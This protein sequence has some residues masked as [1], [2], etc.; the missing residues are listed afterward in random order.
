MTRSK[1]KNLDGNILENIGSALK[2]SKTTIEGFKPMF[3]DL[4]E[5]FK[6][7]KTN[8]F[9]I[10]SI[11]TLTLVIFILFFTLCGLV[12]T[13]DTCDPTDKEKQLKLNSFRNSVQLLLTFIPLLVLSFTLPSHHSTSI[14]RYI[15]LI[16]VI[17]SSLSSLYYL[18]QVGADNSISGVLISIL[19]LICITAVLIAV[20][21]GVN[22]KKFFNKKIKIE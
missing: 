14:F 15:L 18:G 9:L 11:F 22:N 12:N 10:A 6:S 1:R 4:T 3:T 20:F 19:V 2:D 16:V 8:K 7:N 5:Q 17:G 13:V 21:Y